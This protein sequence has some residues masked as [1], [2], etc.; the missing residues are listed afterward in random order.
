MGKSVFANGMEIA[1]KAGDAKVIAAFPDVCMSPPSPPAGPIPVP[2]PDTSMAKDLKKGTKKVKIGSKPA[3]LMGQSFYKTSP[4]GDES[5]TRSFGANVITHQITGKTYFQASS[6]NVSFE[7]KKVCRHLDIATCNHG[8]DP[9]GTVPMANA[10]TMATSGLSSKADAKWGHKR[11]KKRYDCGGNH[12]WECNTAECPDCWDP[13]CE[14]NAEETQSDYS[15]S[16]SGTSEE[17]AEKGKRINKKKIEVGDTGAQIENQAIDI[18]GH[19]TIEHVG[20]KAHC[21]KCHMI[22][23]LDIVTKDSVIE[24]KS[25]SGGVKLR[26]IQQRIAPVAKKCFPDKKLKVAVPKN[27]IEK[28][29]KKMEEKEWKKLGIELI[30]IV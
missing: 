11:G 22:A 23:D 8:S 29:E 21:R 15:E 16:Q 10:E 13:P 17:R 1:H 26:Q 28:L 2:Y 3:A 27:E 12:D 7:G 14:Q 24:V 30:S 9:P 6:M 20:Y 18:L 19:D 5:A 25:S 4:L